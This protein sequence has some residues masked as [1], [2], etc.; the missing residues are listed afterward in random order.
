VVEIQRFSGGIFLYSIFKEFFV[1]I[2]NEPHH[3]FIR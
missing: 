2:L 1:S 3:F